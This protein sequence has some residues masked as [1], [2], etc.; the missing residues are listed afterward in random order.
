MHI[1]K[2]FINPTENQ[3]IIINILQK[4]EAL[5]K[6][7]FAPEQHAEA[8]KNLSPGRSMLN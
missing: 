6:D 2:V 7:N 4:E 3:Q 5:T 8:L 1:I